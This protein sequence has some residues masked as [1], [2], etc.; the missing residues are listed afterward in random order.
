M[1][2]KDQVILITGGGRGI[3]R[4]LVEDL[5][6]HAK[7]I[8]VVDKDADALDDLRSGGS[9]V[10]CYVC[11]LT[12]YNDV[13]R[14]ISTIAIEEPP[15]TVLINNA[16]LI[17]SE[18]LINLLSKDEKTHRLETW[19]KTLDTNLSSVFY[20]TSF[21]VERMVAD[22]TKGAII[23]ISSIAAKGNAGQSAYSAAKAA[24]NALAVTW[25]KELAMFGIRS[26]AIAP[27]FFDAPSTRDALSEANLKKWEKSTPSGRLG[28]LDEISQAIRFVIETDFYNG[29]ILELDGGLRL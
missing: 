9:D 23:N 7:K 27:G 16:G 19:H 2:I 6:H 14:T 13:K 28:E 12:D 1:L 21:V 15:V 20:V 25:S 26:A 5:S 29:K 8:L 24:V 11:D 3:G 4:H 22:R 18:P 10:S 17:H